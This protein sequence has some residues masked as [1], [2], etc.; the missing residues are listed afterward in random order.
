MDKFAAEPT[1]ATTEERQGTSLNAGD[2][3]LAWG[4]PASWKALWRAESLRQHLERPIGERLRHALSLVL[5]R[6]DCE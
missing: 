2:A 5:R 4:E 1:V 6:S 3:K